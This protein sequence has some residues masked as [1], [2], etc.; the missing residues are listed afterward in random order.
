[1]EGFHELSWWSLKISPMSARKFTKIRTKWQFK[2]RRPCSSGHLTSMSLGT[3]AL[4]LLRL[5]SLGL[6]PSLIMWCNPWI[7]RPITIQ[8][9]SIQVV[10][11][12][13]K[14]DWLDLPLRNSEGTIQIMTGLAVI[15]GKYRSCIHVDVVNI[16]SFLSFVEI[17][18]RNVTLEDI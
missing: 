17:M 1:M 6:R 2:S 18:A 11:G 10:W 5:A 14:L 7:D 8:L 3:P 13:G 15:I 9:C 12:K 4:V 16:L